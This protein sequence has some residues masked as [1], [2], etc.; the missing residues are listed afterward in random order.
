M[1][2]A[3]TCNLSTFRRLKQADPKYKISMSCTARS[4]LKDQL[5]KLSALHIN[6]NQSFLIAAAHV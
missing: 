3:H 6:S 1:V 4:C 5:I 2:V